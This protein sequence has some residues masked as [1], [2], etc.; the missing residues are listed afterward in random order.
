MH[1]ILFTLSLSLSFDTT[2]IFHTFH[3]FQFR[4]PFPFTHDSFVIVKDYFYIFY[5][6][7]F[8]VFVAKRIFK[9]LS[10]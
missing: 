4:A 9:I 8:P 1:F 10:L 3:L 5:S 2:I 7:N 6:K